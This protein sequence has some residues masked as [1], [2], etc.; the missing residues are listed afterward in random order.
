MQ[1]S[2]QASAAAAADRR[3]VDLLSVHAEHAEFV[4]LTL[5]RMGVAPAD[6][7][8]C[9]QDVF[10]VVHQRL[11]T[12]DGS[13][14]MTTWLYGI[15]IRV[16]AAYRRRA[17]RRRERVGEDM[18]EAVDEAES[19]EA[20]ASRREGRE[21]LLRVLDEMNLEKRALFVMFGIDEVSC[22]DVA[23]NPR[24]PGRHRAFASPCRAQGVR[25]G[26]EADRGAGE[27]APLLASRRAVMSKPTRW[28]EQEGAPADVRELLRS[29]ARSRALP[30]A[31]RTRSI[32]RLDRYLV[33]PAAAGVLL[34]L[35]GVAIAAGIGLA[36][37]VAV[38]QLP[39]LLHSEPVVPSVDALPARSP[40]SPPVATV[41]PR[42]TTAAAPASSAQVPAPAAPPA[43]PI[44]RNPAP[45]ASPRLAAPAAPTASQPELNPLTREA[46]ML[47]DARA[48]LSRDP[49][50]SLAELDACAAR[51][52]SGTLSIERELLAV[53]ALTRVGRRD[54]ARRRAEALLAAA[55]G[56]I[57]EPRVRSML[58]RLQAP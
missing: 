43:P 49:G 35:K 29:A 37:V 48:S 42:A 40:A 24:D 22:E 45:S 19:P 47:E 21:R 2:A 26:A 28:L 44:P 33:W 4:W 53:D 16:A 39:P 13:S 58:D 41:V 34:W 27:V 36:G 10:V 12:F 54:E 18:D 50:A 25:I 6:V 52:P 38:T 57:Y 17:H 14:R 32:A 11:G 3:E 5:Q 56:S 15:C 20:A 8:D 46:A 30:D 7:E 1:A 55:R 23:E 51:F 9:L 31:V